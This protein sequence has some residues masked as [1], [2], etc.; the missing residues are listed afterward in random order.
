[1]AEQVAKNQVSK[2][3]SLT[4]E[5]DAFIGAQVASRRDQNAS[6][7][8]RATLRLLADVGAGPLA[9]KQVR[10]ADTAFHGR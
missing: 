3:V 10:H 2:N 1:M 8:V 6:M 4:R 9:G 5:L 7:V